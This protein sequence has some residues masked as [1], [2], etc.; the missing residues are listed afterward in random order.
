MWCI[1]FTSLLTYQHLCT[2]L[3]ILDHILI[4]APTRFGVRRHHLQGAP[5]T[6]KL[7]GT[8]QM[9]TGT[10]WPHATGPHFFTKNTQI[11]IIIRT[12]SLN[13]ICSKTVGSLNNFS[14][15]MQHSEFYQNIFPDMYVSYIVESLNHRCTTSRTR[16]TKNTFC[17]TRQYQEKQEQRYAP[18]KPQ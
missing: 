4:I 15:R 1:M 2:I 16:N 7:I 18:T 14:H 5:V 6:C 13:C 9:I 17:P 8:H 11:W 12:F 10:C 3:C